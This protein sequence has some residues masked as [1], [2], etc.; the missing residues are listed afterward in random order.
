MTVGVGG[1]RDDAAGLLAGPLPPGPLLRRQ[2]V[3]AAREQDE[4]VGHEPLAVDRSSS[5]TATSSTHRQFDRIAAA[6][7]P[8]EHDP[9]AVGRHGDVARL[10]EGEPAG[11]GVLPRERVLR[12]GTVRP[13]AG[14]GFGR[15]GRGRCTRRRALAVATVRLRVAIVA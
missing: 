10:A 15:R 2:V 5:A 8:D 12:R 1:V 4:G 13:G 6:A 7:G 11:P 3:V 14:G 9:A